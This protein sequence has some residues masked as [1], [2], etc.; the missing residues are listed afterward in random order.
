MKKP[1]T[2]SAA[3]ISVRPVLIVGHAVV[4]VVAA[5]APVWLPAVVVVDAAEMVVEV[6]GPTQGLTASADDERW[7]GHRA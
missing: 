2:I 7:A 1:T 4:D 3:Y 6:V 5:A